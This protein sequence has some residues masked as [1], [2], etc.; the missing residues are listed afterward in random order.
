MKNN[1]RTIATILVL[2]QIISLCT[3]TNMVHL[4]VNAQE[5]DSIL[6]VAELKPS[7]SALAVD[8]DEPLIISY[9]NID[10]ADYECSINAEGITASIVQGEDYLQCE[11]EAIENVEF[12][13]LT[14]SA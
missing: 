8:I 11:V 3:S 9:E 7:Y 13:T 4:K 6:D 5:N 10:T 14:V 1:S 12:G 2:I